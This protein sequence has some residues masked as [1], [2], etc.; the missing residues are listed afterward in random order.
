MNTDAI[1]LYP[2]A[3]IALAAL[4]KAVETA[5]MSAMWDKYVKEL[6]LC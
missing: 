1:F 2:P 3:Q 4:A 6:L 5:H